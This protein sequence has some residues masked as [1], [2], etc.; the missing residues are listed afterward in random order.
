MSALRAQRDSS[1][2]YANRNLGQSDAGFHAARGGRHDRRLGRGNGRNGHR[3]PSAAAAA[4]R[5]GPDRAADRAQ[6]RGRPNHR[7]SLTEKGERSAGTNFADMAIVLWEEIKSVDD[8]A[9]RR[10]LLKRIA[11]RFVA[12]YRDQVSGETLRE[13]MTAVSRSDGRTRDSVRGRHLER[14]ARVVGPGLPLSGA[15]QEGPR[16]VHDGEDDVVGNVG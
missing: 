3:R 11:D 2:E 15:G 16:R 10:G 7:Y 5:S 1:H 6:G 13:R 8:P 4:Y 14:V 9:I 12:M